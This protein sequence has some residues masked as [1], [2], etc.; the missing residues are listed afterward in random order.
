[1]KIFQILTLL[2]LL[3]TT[4]VFGNF[5][6]IDHV[7]AIVNNKIILYSDVQN[8]IKIIQHYPFCLKIFQDEKLYDKIL[9]QLIVENLIFQENIKI[10][11][12][13]ID[14][15][16][17]YIANCRNIKTNQF[18]K[19][20]D[21]IGIG[22]NQFA[23]EIHRNILNKKI[24]NQIIQK[25]NHYISPAEIENT[26]QKLNFINFNKKFK[27]VHIIIHL[28]TQSLSEQFDVSNNLAKIII[29]KKNLKKNYDSIIKKYYCKNIFPE[30]QI[31]ES[32]WTSWNDIP[33]IFD[34]YLET[35]KIGDII[36]PIQSYDGI[37][38]LEIKD[39]CI[40]KC[41]FP[42]IRV[43]INEIISKDTSDNIDLKQKLLKIKK[44]IE[45][46]S[47]TF[48]IVTKEKYKDFYCN[49]YEHSNSWID[50]NKFNPSI[51]KKILSLKKNEISMPIYTD[52]RWHLVQLIDI[53]KLSYS[54]II[55]ERSYA[56][57]LH[58]KFNEII[59][60]WIKNL[61]STSYIKIIQK[62]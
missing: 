50:L 2:I 5:N 57:L 10:N 35:A 12:S 26:T 32:E 24:F 54:E 14:Q 41:I 23:L 45:N 25:S 58:Q 49:N 16:I 51:Q 27:F 52:S 34:F 38:I 13:Q 11:Q 9:D 46:T 43:K 21:D 40:Q 44:C 15:L 42:V 30:I 19:Y 60:N 28:P 37:H 59:N 3:K 22:Y 8:K 6:H 29:N 62:K 4:I 7:A 20:L 31:E 1:M 39:I 18:Y 33:V 36:G 48:S 47:T 53:N 17:L 61:K 55:H 56:H